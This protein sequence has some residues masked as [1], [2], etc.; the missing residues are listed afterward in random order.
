MLMG[1]LIGG[2][3]VGSAVVLYPFWSAMLWAAILAYSSWPMFLAIRRTLRLGSGWA[4]MVMVLCSALV[5]V[6]PLAFAVP[7]SASD[8][9]RLRGEVELLLQQGLPPAPAWLFD[10]P[11]LGAALH[12]Y[13]AAWAAD[14]S[15]MERFFQP[16]FGMIAQSGLSL[17][18][19][20]AGGVL[21]IIAALF[22]AYFFW[23]GGE[24]MAASMEQVLRRI[25]GERANRLIRITTLTVRGVVYGILGT[26]IVQGFLTAF[27]LWLV[28][29]PRPALLGAVAAALAVLPV[30][31][32]LVWIPAGIWLLGTGHTA[33]GVFLLVYGVGVVSGADSIL[34]PYF[35]SRGAKLPFL[36][37]M[38][39]VLGG[40]L[41]FGLL[42][43][44]LG[45]VLLG[46]GYSLVAEFAGEVAVA[47]NEAE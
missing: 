23:W 25:A 10:V 3:A 40:A 9:E 5:I 6:V 34:R 14:I 47:P 37:T 1:L 46:L 16:Y 28:S 13:W 44:F 21:N 15:A 12:D 36:L 31:A 8:V 11:V 7:R 20:I 2:V 41:A 29:V 26:A 22:I 33:K 39:G 42:G 4:A 30:G 19:A 43:V 35:I 32:P 27:G 17:L 38:L 24:R 45:P 18:L